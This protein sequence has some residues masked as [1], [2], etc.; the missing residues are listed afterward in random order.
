VFGPLDLQ[1]KLVAVLPLPQAKFLEPLEEL[2]SVRK[3][4]TPAE[5]FRLMKPNLMDVYRRGIL[6]LLNICDSSFL[7]SGPLEIGENQPVTHAPVGHRCA[8]DSLSWLGWR[9][10][11][12]VV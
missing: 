10:P 11:K 9:F 7:Q 12:D 2:M 4:I 5:I 6:P 1:T 3:E 8:W